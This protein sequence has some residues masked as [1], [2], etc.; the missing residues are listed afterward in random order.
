METWTNAVARNRS[1]LYC[2]A[3]ALGLLGTLAV[4]VATP[5]VDADLSS[6][7]AA[8]GMDIDDESAKSDSA[9]SNNHANP[10]ADLF[11]ENRRDKVLN[12]TFR[13]PPPPSP[14]RRFAQALPGPS[15]PPYTRI[16]KLSK[17]TTPHNWQINQETCNAEKNKAS[18][19]S[20]PSSPKETETDKEAE[21]D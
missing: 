10:E 13:P 6:K 1:P 17:Q 21:E 20:Q 19:D 11:P 12:P 9:A 15:L 2:F 4:I 7:P 3:N 5:V 18:T 14:S 16:Q 8:T